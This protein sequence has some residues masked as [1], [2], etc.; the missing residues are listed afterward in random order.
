MTNKELR[1]ALLLMGFAVDEKF[2][3]APCKKG[4]VAVFTFVT[5]NS[6]K[7]DSIRYEVRHDRVTWHL[8]PEDVL[9]KLTQLWED[10]DD[11]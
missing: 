6:G 2:E 11:L 7:L 4:K 5:L 10:Y 9:A 1:A 3:H 8:T